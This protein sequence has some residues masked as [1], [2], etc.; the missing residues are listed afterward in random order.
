[1]GEPQQRATRIGTHHATAKIARRGVE[2]T[3]NKLA[4]VHDEVWAMTHNV[5]PANG[6]NLIRPATGAC[7]P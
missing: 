6:A 5:H 7:T 3:S 2:Q 4:D 1:M